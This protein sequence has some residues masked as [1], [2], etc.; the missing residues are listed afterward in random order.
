M[1][2]SNLDGLHHRVH[3]VSDP[4]APKISRHWQYFVANLGLCCPSRQVGAYSR[5]KAPQDGCHLPTLSPGWPS[6]SPA[7][8][9][10][11]R[12]RRSATSAALRARAVPE[13]VRGRRVDQSELRLECNS[14]NLDGASSSRCSAARRQRGRLARAHSSPS[15]CGASACTRFGLRRNKQ[16]VEDRACQGPS[17]RPSFDLCCQTAA[18]LHDRLFAG[19]AVLPCRLGRGLV[20]FVIRPLKSP[21]MQG[22]RW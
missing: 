17:A 9:G 14:I 5:G 13:T 22:E 8:P 11:R 19:N 6:R 1:G 4:P 21:K 7:R 15:E 2:G 10:I 18:A 3:P 12:E 16:V 20:E